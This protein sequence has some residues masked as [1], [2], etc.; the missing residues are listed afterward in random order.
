[1]KNK[2]LYLE[3]CLVGN[4]QD[5]HLLQRGRN[6]YI[7]DI[8]TAVA[9]PSALKPLLNFTFYGQYIFVDVIF[10]QWYWGQIRRRVG[11]QRTLMWSWIL[12]KEILGWCSSLKLVILVCEPNLK[13][14]RLCCTFRKIRKNIENWPLSTPSNWEKESWYIIYHARFF[15]FFFFFPTRK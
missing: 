2:V 3:L 7:C 4:L 11:R 5:I 6:F 10:S 8:S 15:F 12:L 14:S 1:M 13:W 9:N